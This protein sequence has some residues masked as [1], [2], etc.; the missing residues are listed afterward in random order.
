[1]CGIFDGAIR[2]EPRPP[3]YWRA[4]HSY[5]G[6]NCAVRAAFPDLRWKRKNV[7]AQVHRAVNDDGLLGVFAHL[8]IQRDDEHLSLRLWCPAAKPVCDLPGTMKASTRRR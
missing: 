1:M 6:Y 8:D 7:E 2:K 4:R 5:T 3:D